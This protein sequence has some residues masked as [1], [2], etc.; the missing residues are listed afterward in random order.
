MVVV[1]H[2]SISGCIEGDGIAGCGLRGLRPVL[3]SKFK[4]LRPVSGFPETER[5]RG[6]RITTAQYP[7]LLLLVG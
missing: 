2:I 7:L 3:G 4:G 5:S 1:A 6:R